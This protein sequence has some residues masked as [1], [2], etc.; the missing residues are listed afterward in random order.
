M[1]LV[2]QKA[3]TKCGE[4]KSVSEFSPLNGRPRA[5]CRACS[6]REVK[7]WRSQNRG[8]VRAQKIRAYQRDPQ[9]HIAKVAEWRTRKPEMYDAQNKRSWEKIDRV[10]E[11]LRHKQWKLDNPELVRLSGQRYRKNNPVAVS[12]A[13]RR[14]QAAKLRAVARWACNKSM[15]AVYAMARELTTQTGIPHEVDHIVPLQSSIVC[16]LHVEANLQV[17]PSRENRSKANR[18]WPDMP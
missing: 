1:L 2:K 6:A 9:K 7:Q 10:A 18:Y 4:E 13:T 17:L 11:R 15:E 5:Q 16:G 12:A 8:K 14:G 3:C